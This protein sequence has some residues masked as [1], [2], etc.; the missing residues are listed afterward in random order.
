MNRFSLIRGAL[1]ALLGMTLLTAF[2][3]YPTQRMPPQGRVTLAGGGG[4]PGVFVTATVPGASFAHTVITDP[5]GYYD[6]TGLPAGEYQVTAHR[7]G[8]RPPEP[9]TVRLG[10]ENPLPSLVIEPA[11]P[12]PTDLTASA[13]LGLLP[14]G[15]VKRRFIL[16]CT[17]CHTFDDRITLPNGQP[18]TKAAWAEAVSRMLGFAGP[19]SN[20]PVISQGREPEPTATW[21]SV[22]ARPDK[23]Q[24]LAENVGPPENPG[25]AL[26]TEY[27]IPEPQD[28][29]H[30][31]AVLRDGRVLITGMFTHR[32]YLLD[33]GTGEY[34]LEAIPVANANP[35][36][37]EVDEAGDWWVLLGNPRQ[38][39]RRE[40]ATGAWKSWPIGMYP[41]SI[42]LDAAGRVWFNGHFTREPE[43]LGHVRP[44]DGQVT[45]DTMPAHPR[46]ASGFGPIP[47][48]LRIGPGGLVWVSEL[49]G[50]RVVSYDPA[51]D[52]YRVFEMPSPFSGP[53]RLD[54]GSGGEVWI[55]EYS[56]NRLARLD[57]ATGAFEEFELPVPDALPY[58]VR[59]D[60]ARN[61]VWIGTGAADM[62][63]LFD[64]STRRF[65]AYPLP[66]RGAMVR[67]LD[68][69]P[70]NGDLWAAYGASPGV[71]SKVARLRLRS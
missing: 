32:M 54:V 70:R 30:D 46:A 17:G 68:I 8:Y 63:F 14:E 12:G 71:P 35:R 34:G 64:P 45:L 21:L 3:W 20:F 23:L 65:R 29:P 62:V 26:I 4:A 56:G 31:L 60:A 39:A 11:A 37:V 42:G 57:P 5:N 19:Q 49:A 43:L 44:A 55:P 51:G 67:H 27:A 66:T 36:A 15:E 2:D 33:P 69:D 58:V 18:R 22:H 25:S 1:A 16:D 50:N 6:F 59:V 28:L 13:F 48:E 7:P 47:Y 10:G 9:A 52:R 24:I 40:A 61:R 41:H 53:R 38:V